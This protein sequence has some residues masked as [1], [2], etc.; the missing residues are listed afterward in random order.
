MSTDEKLTLV[1]KRCPELVPEHLTSWIADLQTAFE[2][3]GWIDYL[4]Y[5]PIPLDTSIPATE[6]ERETPSAK[7]LNAVT[8][9]RAKAFLLT[10]VGYQHRHGLESYETA[11]EILNAIRIRYGTTLEDGIRLEEAIMNLR[12][13]LDKTIDEHINDYTALLTKILATGASS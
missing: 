2:E 13:P 11:S 8:A 9:R 4:E 1:F 10:G 12:K 7:K 6:T 3:R 5:P